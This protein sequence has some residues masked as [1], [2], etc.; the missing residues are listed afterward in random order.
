MTAASGPFI[1]FSLV[2]NKFISEQTS[3][4]TFFRRNPT[5]AR[6]AFL[7]E[8]DNN[9]TAEIPI[10]STRV[11]VVDATTKNDSPTTADAT[12][13]P[14]VTALPP[15][16]AGLPPIGS[17]PPEFFAQLI[18]TMKSLQAPKLPAKII[19]ESRDHQESVDLAKLQTSML[20]LM[21]VSGDID[22]DEATVKN[23]R[24]ATFSKG[25]KNLL[26]RTAS[27]QV[28]QLSN[29]FVT[30]FTSEP[31]DDDDDTAINP[32]NRLM[33][34]F[35]FPQKFTKAHLN[36]SFQSVDLETGSIYKSTS[37]N[38]FHYAPQTNRVLVKAANSEM[39]E[40]RNETNW[41]IVEKD[42][43]Q[44]SSVIEGVGR[45]T[46]M[47]DV[48]MTCANVCGV[49]LAIVD[50]STSKPILYQFAWKLIKFIENKK[51]KTWMRDNKEAIA[52]L[53]MVFM[54]KIHQL[55][56]YLA[57]FSQ[58]SI[59]TNK[60]E[61]GDVDLETKQIIIAVK[62]A[63][64]FITKMLEHIDEN[65]I[66]KNIPAFAKSLFVEAPEAG[67][68]H[69]L[70]ITETKRS[71]N[72]I[73]TAANEGGR[74]KLPGG[75]DPGNKK[76][77]K[78]FSDR[79]LKMGLF[80]IRKGIPPNKAYPDRIKLKDGAGICPDFNSHGYKCQHPHQ[81]CKTGKHFTNWKHVP[82]DD[83]LVILKH[84][85]ETGSAWLDAE[86]FEKHNSSIPPEFAHLLG[87]ASG[88]K[89]KA[90]KKST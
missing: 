15:L 80:H 41:K 77:R 29:L 55:F 8:E 72:Q 9:P 81:L 12:L 64:K 1:E 36:A 25:F 59:N 57:S 75:D 65:S 71:A 74:R 3:L 14:P 67:V 11:P 90:A 66:P 76:P 33:S 16:P 26:D 79:S 87:D 22:W 46:S 38:P 52:H 44:I 34:L 82:D 35:V 58:N 63:S 5:P 37:I 84:M 27:V 20:K 73:S 50:V 24:L 7:D 45:I 48:A 69:E 49:Q 23:I 86:T 2:G 10:H 19:V 32:L 28:T 85:D 6:A 61:I 21:Y 62:F 30:V 18:E 17:A 53:P 43:K 54:G 31:E 40:E 51:T 47:N 88:P 13:P 42:R 4:K 60:V 78:E 39:E 70:R 68:T 89:K 56:Q 83:K